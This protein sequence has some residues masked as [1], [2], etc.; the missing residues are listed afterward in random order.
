MEEYD[1]VCESPRRQVHVPVLARRV[2]RTAAATTRA[3]GDVGV[4]PFRQRVPG[5]NAVLDDQ[6]VGFV[7]LHVRKQGTAG[8]SSRNP[9][10]D[11]NWFSMTRLV[12][13]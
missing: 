6:D 1:L 11:E 13:V 10:S 3:T 4:V 7:T 12:R 9:G 2:D 5:A 8:I